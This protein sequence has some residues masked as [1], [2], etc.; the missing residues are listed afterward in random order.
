MCI[1]KMVD[2]KDVDKNSIKISSSGKQWTTEGR[3]L[4]ELLENSL[5]VKGNYCYNVRLVF[6]CINE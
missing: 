5:S 4:L 2:L 6:N 1:E 3:L